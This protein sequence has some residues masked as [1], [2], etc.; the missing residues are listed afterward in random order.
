MNARLA[1]AVVTVVLF[2]REQTTDY[3]MTDH[4]L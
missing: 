4:H 2:S 3:V 1:F